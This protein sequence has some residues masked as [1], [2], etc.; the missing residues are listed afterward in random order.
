[1]TTE[2]EVEN[3]ALLQF[4]Y[5]CPSGLVE[6]DGNGTIAIINPAAMNLLMPIVG[7][8]PVT[9]LFQIMDG[10][11][12]ELRNMIHDF[13]WPRGMICEGHRIMTGLSERSPVLACTVM[14]LRQDRF[15][16]MLLDV[17][18]QVARE[19]RLKQAE[20]WFASLVDNVEDVAVLSLDETGH[21]NAVTPAVLRQT[22]F[23]EAA[24]LGQPFESFD[25]PDPDA[26]MPLP[27]EAIVAAQR[28]GWHLHEG[29]HARADGSRY[30]CQRLI[31]VRRRVDETVEGYTMV[32]RAV[33]RKGIDAADLCRMLTHDHLTGVGNRAYFFDEAERQ[34]HRSL[35]DGSPIAL[36]LLDIDYFKRVNDE[37]GHVAGDVVL[38]EVARRCTEGLRPDD[39]FARLGGEEFIAL[40]PATPLPEAGVIAERLRNCLAREPV[41]IGDVQLSITASFGCSALG[42]GV[43]MTLND[44]ITAA[45]SAM[46]CAK[47]GGRNQ[48]ALS[49][50]EEMVG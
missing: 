50:A 21:I 14:K 35:R 47:R 6:F 46:Y 12:P 15:S 32:L 19:R 25:R 38:R 20:I 34:L 24:L 16:G 48:V 1:V 4:L 33:A 45:D 7:R 13:P 8:P 10:C 49:S 30:W 40:L 29:W 37:H 41:D 22:C 3:Q 42:M 27:G 18:E 39:I 28:E 44:L 5:A 17:T 31:A 26:P 9:N 2:L 23:T 43:S 36:I 11:A